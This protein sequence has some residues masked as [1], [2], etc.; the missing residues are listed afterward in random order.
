M[1]EVKAKF[2]DSRL[3][4][5]HSDLYKAHSSRDWISQTRS[6]LALPAGSQF[7]RLFVNVVSKELTIE[8]PLV[9]ERLSAVIL[10]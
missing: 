7:K 9:E 5:Y 10:D 1:R 2:Q 6:S 4:D 3:L 8:V